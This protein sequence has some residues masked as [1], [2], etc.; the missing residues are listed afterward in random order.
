[1]LLSSR[2]TVG[3][4]HI[5]A[6]LP[7]LPLANVHTTLEVKVLTVNTV[8]C[9]VDSWSTFKYTYPSL[10]NALEATLHPLRNTADVPTVPDVSP[11]VFVLMNVLDGVASI[12][13]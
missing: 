11:I 2:D 5:T 6:S 10:A 4:A 8:A 13:W 7:A 3:G 12:F 9:R 1:M